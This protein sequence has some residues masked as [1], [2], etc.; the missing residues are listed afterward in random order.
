MRRAPS[1]SRT[2]KLWQHRGLSFG[3]VL[4]S[5]ALLA[6]CGETSETTES[7]SGIVNR[8]STT[9]TAVVHPTDPSITAS[10]TT[11]G[12]PAKPSMTLSSSAAPAEVQCG[13]I[14]SVEPNQKLV[15]VR[16]VEC[17]TA[18]RVFQQWEKYA[19][20]GETLPEDGWYCY[21]GR[22]GD[23]YNVVCAKDAQPGT[24]AKVTGKQAFVV[25]NQ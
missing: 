3:L 2:G 9:T 16:N 4:L 1:G 20:D 18:R 15:I 13:P 23:G 8:D 17:P 6:A 11:T 19:H 24:S 10:S 12:A 21:L 25:V 22:I 5:A 7:F 14:K